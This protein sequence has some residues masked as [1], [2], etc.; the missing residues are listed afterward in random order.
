MGLLMA[1]GRKHVT[2]T[3]HPDIGILSTGDEL[4]EAGEPLKPGKVYDS[5]K[6]TLISLLKENGFDSLDFGIAVD[7]YVKIYSQHIVLY[8]FIIF[9]NLRVLLILFLILI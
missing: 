4:Q 5:N 7:K 9:I 8:F 3:K 6:I 2:V 1:C